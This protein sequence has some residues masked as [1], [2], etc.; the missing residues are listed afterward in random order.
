MLFNPSLL[1]MPG[2]ISGWA[3]RRSI[4]TLIKGIKHFVRKPSEV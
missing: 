3:V 1:E 4:I 2:S